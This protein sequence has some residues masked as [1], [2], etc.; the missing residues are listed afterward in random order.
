MIMDNKKHNIFDYLFGNKDLEETIQTMVL[1]HCEQISNDVSEIKKSVN[2]LN[3][4]FRIGITYF[5]IFI[6]II[7]SLFYYN[8]ECR[9]NAIEEKID[10]KFQLA[11]A[12][13]N[14]KLDKLETKITK[15][16]KDIQDIK[17][18]K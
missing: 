7:I 11:E 16:E 10:L 9:F 1:K 14:T 18:K 13:Q 17:K 2:D 8:I 15:I 12:K 6:A 5:S 4:K 3:L